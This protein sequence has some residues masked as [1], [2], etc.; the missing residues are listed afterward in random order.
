MLYVSNS[1]VNVSRGWKDD[2]YG[3]TSR[4][5]LW[6]RDWPCLHR[7]LPPSRKV[8]EIMKLTQLSLE[9]QEAIMRDMIKLHLPRAREDEQAYHEDWLRG[10][11][12]FQRE[13][14]K[15][16]KKLRKAWEVLALNY[17]VKS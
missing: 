7:H 4:L 6:L 15:L 12:E 3:N 2:T 9:S 14:W 5:E 17:G 13:D 1:L 11:K 10:Q 8:V 16:A